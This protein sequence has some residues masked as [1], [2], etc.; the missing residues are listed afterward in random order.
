MCPSSLLDAAPTCFA[1]TGLNNLLIFN[2]LILIQ[3]IRWTLLISFDF[4][5]RKK[6]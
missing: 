4:I 2:K 1:A 3:K 5:S 6:P